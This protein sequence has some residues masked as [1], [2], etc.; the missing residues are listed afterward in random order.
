M[1]SQGLEIRVPVPVP[2]GWYRIMIPVPVY[3]NVE[4]FSGG[5]IVFKYIQFGTGDKNTEFEPKP[6]DVKRLSEHLK[7]AVACRCTG[8]SNL[9]RE[10][11][12]L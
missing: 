4:G 6:A 1:W 3:T 12:C 9:D 8:A 10:H 2:V 5:N 11:Q 7:T